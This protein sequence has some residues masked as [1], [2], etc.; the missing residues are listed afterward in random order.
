MPTISD[1]LFHKVVNTTSIPGWRVGS[2]KVV[3]T[4]DTKTFLWLNGFNSGYFQLHTSQKG[5]S[6]HWT[7]LFSFFGQV[8]EFIQVVERS[9]HFLQSTS[10]WLLWMIVIISKVVYCSVFSKCIYITIRN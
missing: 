5:V 4:Y 3:G 2:H 6:I 8:S 1:S 10:T 7:K 9:L